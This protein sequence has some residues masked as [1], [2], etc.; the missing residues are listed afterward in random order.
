LKDWEGDGRIILK[1]IFMK[2]YPVG[3]LTTDLHL[4]LRLRMCGAL[5]SLS[6]H[7]HAMMLKHKK[8]YLYF[9]EIGWRM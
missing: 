5:P 2:Y 3:K 7:L 6:P 1:W 8:T 9:H 4:V